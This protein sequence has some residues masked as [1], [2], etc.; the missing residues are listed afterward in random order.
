MMRFDINKRGKE[1]GIDF[2]SKTD[3]E[4]FGIGG[5]IIVYKE[6]WNEVFCFQYGF[7]Y[8]GIENVL[9]GKRG[10]DNS[11]TIKR[12]VFIQMEYDE[13]TRNLI[14]IG[15]G[16][17]TPSVPPNHWNVHSLVIY[18]TF[19][20][21]DVTDTCQNHF[22]LFCWNETLFGRDSQ[23][24]LYKNNSSEKNRRYNKLNSFQLLI[25]TIKLNKLRYS[26]HQSFV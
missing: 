8:K 11:F 6:N 20:Y 18:N 17:C 4:L 24:F 2:G 3:C 5:D 16:K 26:F 9:C 23:S 13:E 12:F 7:E 15:F 21:T 14:E 10:Y 22:I 19:T 1:C 25:K